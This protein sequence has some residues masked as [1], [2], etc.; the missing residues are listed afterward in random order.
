MKADLQHYFLLRPLRAF[1]IY[2][3]V[4]RHP[5][6]PETNKVRAL[7]ELGALS[8][9]LANR[10]IGSLTDIQYWLHIFRTTPGFR[11][12]QRAQAVLELIAAENY[13]SIYGDR[14]PIEPDAK[15]ILKWLD[16]Y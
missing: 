1:L 15:D 2:Y 5:R 10:Q 12:Y 7:V 11:V 16:E 14:I 9:E 3:E 6:A 8:R 13:V 4:F